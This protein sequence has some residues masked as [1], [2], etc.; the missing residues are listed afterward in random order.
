[1]QKGTRRS[2]FHDEA[3]S[4]K[5]LVGLRKPE[6]NVA[7][8][9]VRNFPFPRNLLRQSSYFILCRIFMLNIRTLCQRAV[10]LCKKIKI[11]P[12]SVTEMFRWFSA[13]KD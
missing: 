1:M 5:N 11:R 3:S 8:T 7:V 13:G 2:L 9:E 12:L 10:F 6:K 4:Y